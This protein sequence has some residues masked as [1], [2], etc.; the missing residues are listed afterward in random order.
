MTFFDFF[1]KCY[2]IYILVHSYSGGA[3]MIGKCF[4]CLKKKEVHRDRKSEKLICTYCYRKIYFVIECFECKEKAI[5]A[6][7]NEKGRPLC[8]KCYKETIFGPCKDCGE[9]RILQ[10]L[11]LCYKCYQRQRRANFRLAI[12]TP[13]IAGHIHQSS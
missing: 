7:Y 11:G 3:E 4:C 8:S 13:S 12:S 9:T 1:L 2:N 10:A 5:L 6:A